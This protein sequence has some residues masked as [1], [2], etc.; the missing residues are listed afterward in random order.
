MRR[1]LCIVCLVFALLIIGI[2]EMFPYEYDYPKE[3]SGEVVLVEG[4]VKGKEIKS[5][6]GQTTYFIYLEPIVSQSVSNAE[7]ISDRNSKLQK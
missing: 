7:Y 2:A 1:P 5:Q 6:N 4:K 3:L